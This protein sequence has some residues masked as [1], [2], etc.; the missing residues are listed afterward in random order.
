MRGAWFYLERAAER[1]RMGRVEGDSFVKGGFVGEIVNGVLRDC[2][3]WAPEIR[4]PKLA[5]YLNAHPGLYEALKALP[6]EDRSAC[7]IDD[8]VVCKRA[9]VVDSKAT[10]AGMNRL[11]EGNEVKD[12]VK[13]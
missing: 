2:R 1:G 13:K 9:E 6:D 12:T 5:V 3:Y 10:A 8:I 7:G 11:V 4:V